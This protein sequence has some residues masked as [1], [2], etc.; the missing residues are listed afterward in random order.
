M[1]DGATLPFHPL[2]G[3]HIVAI[4][5]EA[6]TEESQAFVQ[7][8]ILSLSV[9]GSWHAQ[10]HNSFVFYLWL[11]AG[12]QKSKKCL[13]K[14]GPASLLQRRASWCVRLSSVL[15]KQSHCI[16]KVAGVI[17][18]HSKNLGSDHLLSVH[19]SF[20]CSVLSQKTRF[21]VCAQWL[22]ST[23]EYKKGP[24]GLSDLCVCFFS[25]LLNGCSVAPK[26]PFVLEEAKYPL[27]NASQ[28]G[29]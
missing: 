6:L 20:L 22:E 26:G 10:H 24:T 2:G 23:V 9:S 19:A 12:I 13:A 4:V 17:V 28:E 15:E 1:E 5:Q 7:I 21:I 16:C 14:C 27:P 8:P 25:L 29:E 3:E 18:V 11:V